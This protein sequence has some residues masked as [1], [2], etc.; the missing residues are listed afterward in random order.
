MRNRK[1][2]KYGNADVIK[3]KPH[4]REDLGLEYGDMVDI[5]KV[6][7]QKANNSSNSCCDMSVKVNN[8]VKKK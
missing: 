2:G 7:K 4:D 5:D 1:I 8:G 6:K 3:L